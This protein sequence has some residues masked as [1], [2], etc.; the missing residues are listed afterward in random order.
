MSAQLMPAYIRWLRIG[1]AFTLGAG[2]AFGPEEFRSSP[3]FDLIKTL[4]LTLQGW[5]IVFMGCAILMAT[6]RMIGFACSVFVWLVW[7]TLLAFGPV[8]SW[9][10]IVWPF[11]FALVNCHELGK[12]GMEKTNLVRDEGITSFRAARSRSRAQDRSERHTWNG[13]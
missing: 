12:W 6:T 4:P 3:A 5:G 7:G 10:A 11:F 9:G 1:V 13:W 8:V 2:Y